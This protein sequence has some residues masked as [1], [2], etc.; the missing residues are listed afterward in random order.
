[1]IRV[2]LLSQRQEVSRYQKRAGF[3]EELQK[4]SPIEAGFCGIGHTRWATVGYPVEKNAHPHVDCNSQAAIV[5]NGDITNYYVLRQQLVDKGHIFSSETDSEVIVH[6]IENYASQGH[7]GS[8]VQALKEVEGSYALAV[9]FASSNLLV[10]ARRG[11]PL[12]VGLGQG[13]HYVASDVPAIIE[14]TQQVMYLEDGDMVA[15]TP[16]DVK[17][18]QNE[19]PMTRTVHQVPWK[20]EERGLAGYEHYFLKEVHQQPKVIRDT[21]AGQISSMDPSVN[22][23]LNPINK[24]QLDQILIAGCGS[25]YHA[26]LIG[27]KFFSE[28]SSVN[29]A[30]RIASEVSYLRPGDKRDLGIFV[31]QSG[32][33]ADTLHVAQLAREAGYSTL[34]LTN[35]QHSSISRITDQTIYTNAG[36]EI[37]VA[38]SKSFTSQLVDLFLL[39]LHLFPPPANRFHELTTEMRLL[40]SKA[41]RVLSLQP[42]LK[43]IG[44]RLAPHSSV[45]LVAKGI[46]YPIALEAS[47][48]LKELAYIHAEALVAG[49]L[50]HGPLALLTQDTP[51]VVLAPKDDTYLR[52]LQAIKEMRARRAPI[53]VFTDSYDDTLASL[54]D[55]IVYLP[56]TEQCFFPILMNMALQL[57]AY[58]CARERDYPIDRPRN[59]AKSVTVF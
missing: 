3:V 23:G 40:P 41:Q 9:L 37:S 15:V 27:E 56:S 49:E 20:P 50:K 13:E 47:L 28:Y 5:H 52:V 18:F 55:D 24:G 43:E 8:V 39:G 31:T 45:Y 58:Y 38:A 35:T 30:A 25:A 46:N 6:L 51:V 26:S 57:V 12:V 7:I 22:L 19:V 21:L 2:V 33:T 4:S 44:Q 59:L 54:V 53:T 32:E 34:G 48:K 10:A 29:I 14:H 16:N 36:L 42:Q 1:M 11:S 17:T